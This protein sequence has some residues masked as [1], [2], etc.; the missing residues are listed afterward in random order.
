MDVTPKIK[1]AI[2]KFFETFNT[3]T[4]DEKIYFLVE[5]DKTIKKSS[6]ADKK[7]Y[8][9]LLSSAK[10]GKTIEDTINMLKGAKSE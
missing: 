6:G 5:I 1:D 7:L 10:E 8:L 9:T 4:A 3:L 2:N